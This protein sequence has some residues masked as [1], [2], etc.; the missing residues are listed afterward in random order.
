MES[1]AMELKISN[2]AKKD[3]ADRTSISQQALVNSLLNEK[4]AV[5]PVAQ[6]IAQPA[7]VKTWG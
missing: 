1:N 2:N 3:K 6:P 4:Q 5:Q 7:P